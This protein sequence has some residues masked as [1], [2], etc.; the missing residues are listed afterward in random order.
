MTALSFPSSPTDGQLYERF[1]Y[2]ATRGVWEKN[3]YAVI[4]GGTEVDYTDGNGVDWHAHIF[5]SSDT[6][7]VHTTGMLD[8]FC[9]GGGGSAT[10]WYG[11]QSQG[12]AGAARWGFFEYDEVGDYTVIVGGDSSI[13]KPSAN[14]V[15]GSGHGQNG[16][17]RNDSNGGGSQAGGG[18]SGG[19]VS[20]NGGT[21]SGGGAGG[22]VFGGASE[23][24]GIML[25]YET[26]SLVEYGHGGDRGHSIATGEAQARG[27]GGG[28]N[29]WSA[30]AGGKPGLVVVR[31]KV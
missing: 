9:L 3:E 5:T 15:I 20:R 24:D 6:L 17:G 2:N 10:S 28:N 30:N 1:K 18:G 23:T 7:T 16:N 4:S 14:Y 8:T 22:T 25:D 12:G 29:Q 11:H 27:S 26:G 19:G 31:Y 13:V 21:T